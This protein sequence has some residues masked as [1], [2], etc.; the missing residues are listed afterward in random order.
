M[1][2]T[3]LGKGKYLQLVQR[4][5]WEYCERIVGNGVVLVVAVT[6]AGKLLLVEQFR[7]SVS[8]Q[9]IELPAGL[10]GDGQTAGEALADAAKR[11]LLEETGYGA[12]AMVFLSEGP[13]SSGLTNETVTIFW[14]EGLEKKH[15]GGGDDSEAIEVHEVKLE[16]VDKF[17][18]DKAAKGS[19]IDPKTF[20]A[21]YFAQQKLKNKI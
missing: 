19:K 4:N 1:P 7:P 6:D 20:S 10:S 11:E 5:G 18:R 16:D 14:A 3:V 17:L 9:V 15:A 13:V 2:E 8:A 21:L 12:K